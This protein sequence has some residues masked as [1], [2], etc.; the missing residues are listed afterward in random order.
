MK[1]FSNCDI[2]WALVKELCNR[3]IIVFE[4]LSDGGIQIP[5]HINTILLEVGRNNLVEELGDC[6]VVCLEGPWDCITTLSAKELCDSDVVAVE[7][8]ADNIVEELGH[9]GVVSVE[10]LTQGWLHLSRVE[11]AAAWGAEE[12]GHTNIVIGLVQELGD[13][14]IVLLLS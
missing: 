6:N 9:W 1:E 12:F 7:E 11:E 8:L 2:V 10:E 4:E 5:A 3:D 14:H 13:S